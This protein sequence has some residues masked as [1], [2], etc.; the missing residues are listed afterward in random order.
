MTNILTSRGFWRWVVL[1]VVTV[2]LAA[3]IWFLGPKLEVAGDAPLADILPRALCLVLVL[4]VDVLIVLSWHWRREPKGQA[5]PGGSNGARAV[6]PTAPDGKAEGQITAMEQG[7]ARALGVLRSMRES[8][9]W[10]HSYVYQLPWYLVFGL[11]GSGKTSLIRG[12]GLRFPITEGRSGA[13]QMIAQGVNSAFF[14]TDDAVLVDTEGPFRP[15]GSVAPGGNPIWNGFVGLIK[16]YRARQP[17]NGLILTLSLPDLERWSE[18]ERHAQGTEFR[19]QLVALQARL[20]VRFPIYIALTKVDSVPGFH[21]F[22]E[23]ISP[24]ERNGVFGLTLPLCDENAQTKDGESIFTFIDREYFNLM[25]WQ[26]PRVLERVNTQSDP[27]RGFDTFMFLPQMA[28]LKP[29]ICDFLEIMFKPNGYERPLLLRGMYFTSADT[30][31]SDA[32]PHYRLIQSERAKDAVAGERRRIGYF[33]HDALEKVVFGEAGLVEVDPDVQRRQK[34][35]LF[36]ITGLGALLAI[37]LT[38]WWTVSFI[39]N[40]N[41]LLQVGRSAEKIEP[42]IS[43]LGNDPTVSVPG[44]EDF[45]TVLPVLTALAALPTGWN[46]RDKPVPLQMTGGLNQ[47]RFLAPVTRTEYTDALQTLFLHRLEAMMQRQ[48]E[49]NLTKPSNLY[50]ALMVYLMFGGAGPMDKDLVQEWMRREWSVAYPGPGQAPLRAA[51]AVQLTNLLEAGFPPIEMNVGLIVRARAVLNQYPTAE[52]GLAIIQNLPEV[53]NLQPWTVAESAGPLASY[54]LV[55]RSGKTLAEGISGMYTADNFFSVILP[56][57]A[58][59]AEVL[60]HEDWVRTP[61]NNSTPTLVRLTRLK[62]DMLNLYTSDYA[63]EW[64]ALL[65]DVTLAP[66]SNLQQEM[67]VLQSVVG[68]P[69]PL[70]LYLTAV[71][72]QT[73]LTPPAPPV[74]VPGASAAKA[75]LSN[76]LSSAPSPGQAVTNR[77]S[78]LHQ[79]TNGT[80]APVDDVIKALAQLR[81]VIGPAASMGDAS[82]AQVT[83][84]TSGASFAQIMGQLKLS[85]LSAPPAIADSI[86]SLVRQTSTIANAGVR[87]DLNTTWKA[88]VLPFCQAAIN[89]RYPFENAQ[90]EVTFAD[91]SKMFAPGGLLDKFFDKQLKPFVDTGSAPWKLLANAGARPDISPAAL[92]YFE[93]ASRIRAMFFAAGATAPQLDFE[94]VPTRLDPA[95]LRV[96]LDIDGQALVYQY[97]PTLPL[98]VKWPG[99]SGVMRVEFGNQEP[100]Q[101]A[102]VSVTGPWALFRFLNARGLSRINANSFAFNVN[103]GPRSASFTL[104]ASSVNNPFRQNPLTGFRCLP[105]LVPS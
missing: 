103:L 61:V 10:G 27:V 48:I 72:Q 76:L 13:G 73:T 20:K 89:G 85:T 86:M 9:R 63:A 52:R 37:G 8:R 79:F 40:R 77:F 83:E 1:T 56:A 39:D 7:M 55:R 6:V 31:E 59:A 91:F 41:L 15:D 33:I 14:F 2:G 35:L 34:R 101:P 5:M 28:T 17:I 38:A 3:A 82:P 12:S 87:E 96:R 100:G 81:M 16:K 19:H 30:Q 57:I 24:E 84:L 64:E 32:K 42:L 74:T 66:F 62:S 25:K 102:A 68:P 58:K 90:N 51:L 105:S 67:A 60:V 95:A 71:A 97:G 65:S 99:A 98:A 21:A 46:E 94:I 104:E 54:A 4:L 43:A 78:G 22:F 88:Q 69:S 26:L 23:G 80:P 49:D 47:E 50:G 29:I 70:K 75:E 11:P 45:S 53:K 93:Q 18:T 92:G 36:G 44:R